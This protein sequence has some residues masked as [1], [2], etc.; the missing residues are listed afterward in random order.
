MSSPPD[1]P[2]GSYVPWYD[3][4]P[5]TAQAG[6]P[7]DEVR[8][9]SWVPDGEQA[10]VE[11]VFAPEAEASLARLSHQILPD[12]EAFRRTLTQ[13]LKADPRPLYRW[14]RQQRDQGSAA[15][16][17]LHVDGVVARCR[18]ESPSMDYLTVVITTLT[19]QSEHQGYPWY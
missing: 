11:V 1:L 15:E 10:P 18:F 17:D 8:V 9:P 2:V 19:P 5:T 6:G 13:S 12:A 7:V 14:K 3:A 16:Y 4:P